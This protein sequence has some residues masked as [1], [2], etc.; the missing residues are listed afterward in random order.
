V[1]AKARPRWDLVLYSYCSAALEG[2]K[3]GFESRVAS[4]GQFG[5]FGAGGEQ[6]VETETK[7]R[8]SRNVSRVHARAVAE[9][10]GSS[11]SL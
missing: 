10:A 6:G 4:T 8:D 3:T 9:W 2:M 7:E 11:K 1:A 5:V